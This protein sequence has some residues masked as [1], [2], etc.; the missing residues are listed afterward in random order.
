MLF[1]PSS[2]IREDIPELRSRDQNLEIFQSNKSRIDI[3]K[4][5]MNCFRR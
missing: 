5:G 1:L 3:F 4:D 2:N